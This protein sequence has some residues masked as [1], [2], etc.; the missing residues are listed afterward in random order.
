MASSVQLIRVA[1][2]PAN[3][4]CRVLL[5]RLLSRFGNAIEFWTISCLS[6]R[7]LGDPR[8]FINDQ[9]DDLWRCL[10][11]LRLALAERDG[12]L[13]PVLQDQLAKLA[14][15]SADLRDVFEVLADFAIV[16]VSELESALMQLAA[17]WE[18]WKLR[19]TLVG[20]IL[21]L[22]APLP[23]VTSEQE[24]FHRQNLDTLFDRFYSARQTSSPSII[25]RP[26]AG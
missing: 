25:H 20:S 8:P 5:E 7:E 3:Y 2:T 22:S 12:D 15:A 10:Q 16:P 9:W 14:R 13:H 19:I 11:N 4:R 17:L 21:P 26:P 23:S 6:Q 18:E 24:M 1:D